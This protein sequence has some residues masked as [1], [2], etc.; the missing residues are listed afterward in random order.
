MKMPKITLP[1]H[2]VHPQTV[3]YISDRE[4]EFLLSEWVFNCL[5]L[6]QHF[7]EVLLKKVYFETEL[8]MWQNHVATMI[9]WCATKPLHFSENTSRKASENLFLLTHS[10]RKVKYTSGD[11]FTWARNS[12]SQPSLVSWSR[13]MDSLMSAFRMLRCIRYNHLMRK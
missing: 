7:Y 6:F 5:L 8:Q 9:R 1:K 10:T 2:K 12:T 4:I 11:F 13:N 3:K